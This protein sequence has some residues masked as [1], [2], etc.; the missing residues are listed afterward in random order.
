MRA[1]FISLLAVA[2]MAMIG[3]ESESGSYNSTAPSVQQ[4]SQ[5]A[6]QEMQSKD[7]HLQD[8]MNNCVGYVIFPEVG[9]GALGVGGAGG[10]GVLYRNGQPVGTVT[11][12]QLSLGPQVGGETYSELIVFQNEK[13]L[14][15]LMN[16]S[17]EFGAQAS[18]SVV[19]AGAA[20][21]TQ[22]DH[23]V[24]VFILPKGGLMAGASISGQKFNYHGDSDS[25]INNNSGT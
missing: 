17:L 25:N 22:F 11:M 21:G 12:S 4:R 14:N 3:C 23:G 15:R 2:A 19:K 7:A 16:D 9:K 13:A 6:L 20:A 18:A 24:A 1:T 8:M 10:S 5:L